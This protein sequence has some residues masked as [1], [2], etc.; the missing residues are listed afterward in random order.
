MTQLSSKKF[1]SP[2]RLPATETS[3]V[4]AKSP[5]LAK[6]CQQLPSWSTCFPQQTCIRAI[7]LPTL[8]MCRLVAVDVRASLLLFRF[9]TVVAE[10]RLLLGV[11]AVIAENYSQLPSSCCL[12]ISRSCPGISQGSTPFSLTSRFPKCCQ[13]SISCA[14]CRP[15]PGCGSPSLCLRAT[16]ATLS[17]GWVASES[18]PHWS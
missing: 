2:T 18:A 14:G 11:D 13:P 15:I 9:N 3:P 7:K 10:T 1:A 16:P 4:W 12:G 6:L 5:S 8:Q 17:L